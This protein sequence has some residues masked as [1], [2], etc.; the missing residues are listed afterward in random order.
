MSDREIRGGTD[1]A[2]AT[3]SGTVS[4]TVSDADAAHGRSLPILVLAALGLVYGDIGTSPLYTMAECFH[5]QHG[6]ALT[7][8]NV[9]GVVSL[10]FWALVIVI[11]VKYVGFI[12]RADNRGE[13][14]VLALMA[15]ASRRSDQSRPRVRLAIVAMGLFGAALLYG[16]GILTP[17]I[18]VLGAMEGLGVQAPSLHHWALPI[19]MVILIA[20]FAVQS[21]GSTRIGAFFG[22]VVLTWFVVIA[23]LGLVGIVREPAILSALSPHHAVRFFAANGWIGFVALSAVFLA[24]TGGEALYADI[25]HFGR[26]PMRFGWFLVALPAL[27]LNYFGQGALLLRD[28]SAISNPF[29]LLAPSWFMPILLVIATAAAAVASQAVIS[30]AFS[31]TRQAVQLGY[32]PRLEIR[33]TS[34][35]AIGQIY[36]PFVNW[37]LAFL[38]L[39]LVLAYRSAANLAGAYGIAVS[40]TMVLT[41]I[42]TFFVARRI[43]NWRR[44]VI[45]IVIGGFLIVDLAFLGSNLTKLAAGGWFPLAVGI[46]VFTLLTTWRRGRDELARRLEERAFPLDAFLRDLVAHPLQRVPGVSIFMSTS[47]AATPVALLHN[48]KHNKVLHET[49]VILEMRTEEV[50]HVRKDEERIQVE[51]LEQ[52]FHRVTARFGFMD[53]PDVGRVLDACHARG[54]DWPAGKTTFFLGRTTLIPTTRKGMARWRKRLFILMARNAERATAYFNIPPGRVVELGIQVEL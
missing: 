1:P 37:A 35:H 40:T 50:P 16:D 20:L 11:S 32:L 45:F 22:P 49:V 14:G 7:A 36:V 33:H 44:R 41:T 5:P 54:F 51:V 15:L 29:Y 26:R 47:R 8:A 17:A 25:G 2:D 48:V 4:G 27:L 30:G 52:G 53:E 31:L 19:S 43:W 9:V 23:T 38:T 34:R 28:P 12:L 39:A 46:V 18:S 24:V 42:L 21:H 6:L 3:M 10:I 13:G